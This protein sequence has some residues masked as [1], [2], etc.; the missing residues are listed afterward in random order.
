MKNKVIGKSIAFIIMI[1][2]L[3]GI[4][5]S[6]TKLVQAE[7][8]YNYAKA[9][10]LSMYFYDANKCGSV[11]S[12]SKLSWRGDC[13]TEDAKIPLKPRDEEGYGTNLSASFISSNLQALDPDGDGCVDLSG[14]FHDA[15]D[16]VNF[17]LPQSYS[18]STLGWGYYE[19]RDSYVSIG[20]QGH[21]EDILRWFNDYFLR[22]TFRDAEGNVVAFAYQVG[23]GT[24]DHNYWGP[25]ELQTTSRPAFFASVE[26]PASDQCAGAAAS[27][28]IN[29]LNF[30]D[31]DS[32]YAETCLETAIALYEFAKENRGLGFSG[33]FYNSSYD[34]DEMSWAAVWL[35]IA[36]DDY[37]YIEDIISVDSSGTY[38][39]YMK[40]IVQT[41]DSTWQNI[42]VHSWDTVWGGVFAKLAPVTDDPEHWYFFRWNIEYWSGVP[43]E[44]PNDGTFLATSPA[45]YRMLTTWGSARY[46]MAAQMCALVYNKYEPKQEFVDWC[47]GQTD[48]LLGDNPMDTCYLVGYAEN[49]AVNPHHR[50]SHGSTT[51]SMLVPEHQ[52]HVLWGALVGGPDETDFHRDDITDYI[53]NEVAIDYNAGCVGALAGLYEI[54]GQGQEPD[55]SVPEYQVDEKPYYVTAKI[56]QEN[57]ERTQL[58]IK[59]FND[60]TCPPRLEDNLKAKY[61]FNISEMMEKGQSID[62]ISVQV[63]YD[64][65][66]TL[67]G[68]GVDINGPYP[69]NAEEG[70]YYVELDWSNLAFHGNREIQLALVPAQDSSYEVNWNPT[71][72]WSRQGITLQE[73]QTTYI[74]LYIDDEL[75]Y[76]TEAG[77]QGMDVSID[78]VEPLDGFVADYTVEQTVIPFAASVDAGDETISKVE[79]FADNVKIGEDDTA[80]YSILYTPE[81]NL[82]EKSKK[83]KLTSKAITSSGY[84]IFSKPVNI[85]VRFKEA[86]SEDPVEESDLQLRMIDDT[87][88][89]SNTISLKFAL[90]NIGKQNMDLSNVKLRYYY[91]KDSNASQV[92]Y[93][94]HAG[95]ALNSAPWYATVSDD[96]KGNFVDMGSGIEGADTYFE[97]SLEDMEYDLLPG[98]DL[99]CQIRIANSNWANFNQEN[100]YSYQN[101]DHVVLL[102]DDIV[103][104]GIEPK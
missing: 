10:Q 36:T 44:N 81:N 62:D 17:G 8:K 100:D 80:P 63:M 12:D 85:T 79:F 97:L 102:V 22:C 3:F 69:W 9:L 51:N 33:G 92:F 37:S 38:T 72:D 32:E 25:P 40:K 41:T 73:A 45:G 27:L 96:L 26:T 16:H 75:V 20:E 65:A 43:H 87:N 66:K 89:N 24:T 29:Y 78:I 14:G 13:H 21:M 67:D 48:Y 53:Y 19:F 7:E 64:Q 70:I 39:G 61:F 11:A 46:N 28:A 23:D 82:D 5:S 15:G 18:A 49:S 55:P 35:N 58:T 34:E 71:N 90:N 101:V 91:T 52:R 47:K 57:S 77:E 103:V 31:T 104:S 56:E 86:G 30:K 1:S 84:E 94:D 50:A 93:C 98:K 2:M 42:W 4:V 59:V 88:Q 68:V 60:T 83:I 95:M 54:Y 99:D 76:G 6:P 74:P